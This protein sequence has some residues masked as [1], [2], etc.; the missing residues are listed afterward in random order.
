[1]ERIEINPPAWKMALLVMGMAAFVFVGLLMVVFGSLVVKA[2]GAIGI[3][4]FGGVCG[5]GL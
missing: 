5:Y 2:L 1:L 3:V 4:F